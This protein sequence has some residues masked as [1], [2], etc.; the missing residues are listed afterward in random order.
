MQESIGARLKAVRL[1][2]GL[3][4]NAL[5][6]KAG[7]DWHTV[8]KAEAGEN[9]NWLTLKRLAN[10]LDCHATIELVRRKKDAR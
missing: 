6:D 5:A 9:V 8:A 7:I 4:I 10:A 1:R 2:L 3:S